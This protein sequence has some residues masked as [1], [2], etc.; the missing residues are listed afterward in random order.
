[1]QALVGLSVGSVEAANSAGFI[2]M[3]PLTFVS[4]AFVSTA[5]MPDWLGAIADA[6]PFTVVTNA[7][8]SLS[9]GNPVGDDLW[10]SI[11]W[12]FGIIAVFA[13]LSIRKFTRSTAAR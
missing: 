5:S 4:S 13:A 8:R 1:M 9:N 7:A 11:V 3:F 12:S 2:W 6:N 10:L